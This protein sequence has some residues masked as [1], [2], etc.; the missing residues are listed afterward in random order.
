MYALV[1]LSAAEPP[2]SRHGSDGSA[3]TQK[4]FD[5]MGGHQG[6]RST[7]DEWLTPPEIVRHLGEFDLDP[8]ATCDAAHGS[9][10]IVLARKSY[11]KCDDG[12]R[13]P[14]AGRVWLNPPYGKETGRWITRLADHKNG[15]ALIFARTDVGYFQD[16]IFPKAHALLF[17]MGRFKFLRADGTKPKF[18]GGAPSVLV[19]FGEENAQQLYKLDLDGYCVRLRFQGL[20]TGGVTGRRILFHV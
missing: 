2:A 7:T 16:F 6:S 5:G 19:A 13:Q 10:A 12:L 8:A 9:K 15:I 1:L 4:T 14:W 17:V 20:T 3:L 18:N 11:C